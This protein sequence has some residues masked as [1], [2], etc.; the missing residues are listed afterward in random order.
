MPIMPAPSRQSDT[1]DKHVKPHLVWPRVMFSLH[2]DH[3]S[4][5]YSGQ[6]SLRL[7]EASHLY[8]SRILKFLPA[9][10]CL[11]LL[12]KR[13][14]LDQP[15]NFLGWDLNDSGKSRAPSD[16]QTLE[17]CFVLFF[18]DVAS[19]TCVLTTSVVTSWSCSP[20]AQTLS[21]NKPS[22][23]SSPF[24]QSWRNSTDV[25]HNFIT[26]GQESGDLWVLPCWP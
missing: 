13:E 4:V 14:Q 2:F 12:R 16:L 15:W 5:I 24:R 23:T 8:P 22:A 19:L 7:S 11:S 6:S 25:T 20:W 18:A 1:V 9:L 17:S 21:F 10:L 26:S 3:F